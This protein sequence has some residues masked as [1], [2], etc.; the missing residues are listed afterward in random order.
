MTNKQALTL[1]LTGALNFVLCVL[2]GFFFVTGDWH[3][4]AVF[5]AYAVGAGTLFGYLDRRWAR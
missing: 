3:P 2:G 4:A 5:L 1:I